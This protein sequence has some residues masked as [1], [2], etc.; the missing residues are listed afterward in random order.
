MN[1]TLKVWCNQYENIYP[2]SDYAWNFVCGLVFIHFSI[3]DSKLMIELFSR[4]HMIGSYLIRLK[5]WSD[6][7]HCALLTP[8]NTV[9]ESVWPSGVREIP[10]DEWVQ[11]K[12]KIDKKERIVPDETK[13][14][15]FLRSKIGKKYD[16][17]AIIGI[18]IERNWRDPNEWYCSELNEAALA[19][20]GLE[21]FDPLVTKFISPE[22]RWIIK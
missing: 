8:D 10:Y 13:T 19:A 18:A 20:G 11:G 12:T 6:W 3:S 22:N 5:T 2:C 4:S 15:A 7:S 1:V 17:F 9:I 21:I 16:T 14:I